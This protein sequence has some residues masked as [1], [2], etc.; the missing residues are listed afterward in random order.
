MLYTYYVHLVHVGE[1]RSNRSSFL[2][3]FNVELLILLISNSVKMPWI[4]FLVHHEGLLLFSLIFELTCLK[5]NYH[6]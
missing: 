5:I 2:S 6:V 4:Q 3:F 1:V